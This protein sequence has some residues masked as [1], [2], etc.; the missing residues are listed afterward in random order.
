MSKKVLKVLK[1]IRDKD[2]REIM[3]KNFNSIIPVWTH[4]QMAWVNDVYKTFHDHEKFVIVMHLLK[5]T[6]DSYSKNFVK[7]NYDEFFSQNRVEIETI[8]ITEISKDL[9]IP[10]ETTRRKVNELEEL[11]AIKKI[12][13]SFIIE[14]D[15]WPNIK[16][17]N[18]VN[19]MSRFFSAFSIMLY[20]DGFIS[21][22]ISTQRLVNT[23]Q[24]YFSHVW[25]LYYE[26]Q[27]PMLLA[28]K[29]VYGDLESFHVCGTI[30]S[31]HALNSQKNDNSEMSKEFYLEKYFFDATK[32]FVG[33]NAM[34]ISDITGIPR[35]TVIR[36]L[37]KLMKEKFIKIDEKKHYSVTGI[38][39]AKLLEVQNI[40]F[41]SLSKITSKVY[42]LTLMTTN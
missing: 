18:T 40:T 2:I 1:Q 5:K 41:N 9:N 42:N 39:K 6:F 12:K 23:C 14:R 7:L 24:E 22:P 4:M 25:K 32:D 30:I 31:N 10:K 8:N 20:K 11:G 27:I 21:E 17:E 29:K 34:S 36:K 3:E 19:R 37:N 38:H 33:I 15:A 13:K 26:M 35:A 16:P 28:F